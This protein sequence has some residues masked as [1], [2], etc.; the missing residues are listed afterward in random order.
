MQITKLDI[1]D[2]IEILEDTIKEGKRHVHYKRTKELAELYKKLMTGDNQDDLIVIYRQRET[3]EQQAQRIR[4]TNSATKHINAKILNQFKEVDRVDNIVDKVFYADEKSTRQTQI[5]EINDRISKFNNGKSLKKYLDEAYK[6]LNFYDPNAWIVTEIH[7]FDPIKEKPYV[8]PVEVYSHQAINYK[9]INGQLQYLIVQFEKK[10]LQKTGDQTL[11]TTNT[12]QNIHKP[13][14]E[15]GF[16]YTIYA[17][18]YAIVYDQIG[19]ADIPSEDAEVIKLKDN[20]NKEF[21]F[22]RTIVETKSKVTPAICVGYNPDP[23]TNRETYVS[24]IDPSTKIQNDIIRAKSEYD[25]ANLAHGYVQKL[26][27]GNPCDYTTEGGDRCKDGQLISGQTCPK[28]QGSGQKQFHTTPQDIILVR[29]AED[30]DSHIPLS[31]FVYC[32]PIPT[33]LIDRHKNDVIEYE[34]MVSKA[35]FNV[36]VF[37]RSEIAVTATEKKLDLRNIYNVFESYG[38]QYSEVYKFQVKM[39]A[40]HLDADEGLIIEHSFPGDFKMES[41]DELIAQLKEAKASGAASEVIEYISEQILAKQNIDNPETVE[42]IKAKEHWKPFKS[43]SDQERTLVLNQLPSTDESKILWLYWDRI[44]RDIEID[45]ITSKEKA[46]FHKLPKDMQLKKIQEK[47][48][49]LKT[50][51]QQAEDKKNLQVT[52]VFGKSAFKAA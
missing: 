50:E 17:P 33:D 45:E 46:P 13:K 16:R 24:I 18:D 2:L 35:I 29:R 21:T 30:K 41:V 36:N 37:D 34:K 27:Y 15:K 48:E 10:I 9:K 19:T 39:A 26:M 42:M 52:Q 31:D 7:Q 12:G 6:H 43:K 51:V 1:P 28:C 40:I 8:Y 22:A 23:E 3:P 14:E 47:V 49:I 44:F 4:I 5:S 20:A 38:Q 11:P 32:V 25:A